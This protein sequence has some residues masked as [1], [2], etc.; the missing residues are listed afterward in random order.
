MAYDNLGIDL[1][2]TYGF[3][4]DDYDTARLPKLPEEDQQKWYSKFYYQ[5]RP[6][7]SEQLK[8][9]FAKGNTMDPKNALLPGSFDLL[10]KQPEIE[11][12]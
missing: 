10:A 9:L 6:V 2:R 11:N 8:S 3:G 7:L 1:S 5:G 12:D 4:F